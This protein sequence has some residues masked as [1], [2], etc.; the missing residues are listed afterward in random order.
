[1]GMTPPSRLSHNLQ[2]NPPVNAGGFHALIAKQGKEAGGVRY[3]QIAG[4]TVAMDTFG[5][6][7][8]Q[9][10]PY[11]IGQWDSVDIT[12]RSDWRA[13]QARQPHLLE[14]DC[15]YMATGSSFYRQLLGYQGMLLHAS[16]VVAEGR[17]Y[18][19]TAPSGTGKST[20]TALWLKCFPDAVILNDDKPAIRLEG[21]G[22]YAYG[23]P[24][25]GKTDCSCNLKVP[26][27]GICVLRRGT[28]NQIRPYSGRGAVRDLLEQTVRPRDAELISNL[29]TVLDGV[30]SRVGIWEMECTMERE[31]AW[32]AYEAMSGRNGGQ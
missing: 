18:L 10:E 2:A 21:D 6:T 4:L 26:L 5:R 25:S 15:E 11:A 1:M 28:E 32:M 8:A 17:A 30:M 22:V 23:T 9:A 27:A 12:V 19:F 20:H 3:Y 29:L 13:L 31:A 7:L 24:W 16:A 14:E